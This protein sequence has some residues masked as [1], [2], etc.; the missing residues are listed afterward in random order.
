[1]EPLLSRRPC[2]ECGHC[3][4]TARSVQ[5]L[6]IHIRQHEDGDNGKEPALLTP[7]ES[8]RFD[9]IC[10][11]SEGET[12]IEPIAE[13]VEG[14]STDTSPDCGSEKAKSIKT[15]QVSR[16]TSSLL[17]TPE[18]CKL[19]NISELND[20]K[21]AD[22][23]SSAIESP[24]EMVTV[25]SL[26]RTAEPS[27]PA[28]ASD[29]VRETT[30]KSAATCERT[31][32]GNDPTASITTSICSGPSKTSECHIGCMVSQ[33]SNQSVNRAAEALKQMTT[34]ETDAPPVQCSSLLHPDSA[35]R[36]P[37]VMN[38]LLSGQ[39]CPE[40]SIPTRT[41]VVDP[42]GNLT[43]D[44]QVESMA[45]GHQ[46]TDNDSNSLTLCITN[47]TSFAK[48]G[49]ENQSTSMSEPL[50]MEA[51]LSETDTAST[52]S[53]AL[54]CSS[55]YASSLPQCALDDSVSAL[56]TSEPLLI[57]PDT[58]KAQSEGIATKFGFQTD[59]WKE[60]LE[61]KNV[62]NVRPEK[63]NGEAASDGC[64]LY[65]D[66]TSAVNTELQ[67]KEEPPD[68]GFVTSNT[69]VVGSGLATAEDNSSE[70]YTCSYCDYKCVHALEAR[71]HLLKHTATSRSL[72][73]SRTLLDPPVMRKKLGFKMCC[74]T[75]GCC[76]TTTD[77]LSL[78]VHLYFQHKQTYK[79][80]YY[81]AYCKF[82]SPVLECVRRHMKRGHKERRVGEDED[83]ENE[84]EEVI[85]KASK[86]SD[87]LETKDPDV[88]RMTEEVEQER[89]EEEK[90]RTEDEVCK[91]KVME[92]THS[93]EQSQKGESLFPTR[94]LDR[95]N[96]LRKTS[97]EQH[98]I[99]VKKM[100]GKEEVSEPPQVPVHLVKS[101]LQNTEPIDKQPPEGPA[102]PSRE[103]LSPHG[104]SCLE[105]TGQEQSDGT[106][107]D[108]QSQPDMSR[109]ASPG[110]VYPCPK[111]CLPFYGHNQRL[112]HLVN[113][114]RATEYIAGKLLS[115]PR[116]A[117]EEG[118]DKSRPVVNFK[119][120][121]CAYLNTD[122]KDVMKH[123]NQ[124]HK[125]M[126]DKTK[127][128]NTGKNWTPMLLPG[129]WQ[130]P[131]RE[132]QPK[133]GSSWQEGPAKGSRYETLITDTVIKEEP[134][135]EV[136]SSWND[137]ENPS[138]T[139]MADGKSPAEHALSVQKKQLT[140]GEKL[141]KAKEEST[142]NHIK[143]EESKA[144]V[145]ARG[146]TIKSWSKGCACSGC[147]PT[148]PRHMK[149]KTRKK[150]RNETANL[151]KDS[152]KFSDDK[153]QGMETSDKD[154]EPSTEVA[155][156]PKRKKR[157]RER[158]SQ[159]QSS[160]DNTRTQDDDK[161][162]TFPVKQQLAESQCSSTEQSFNTVILGSKDVDS[163]PVGGED[164]DEFDNLLHGHEGVDID[165]P[166]LYWNSDDDEDKEM[167]LL[168]S[169]LQLLEEGTGGES[170]SPADD[171]MPELVPE[172]HLR[173]VSNGPDGDI[174]NEAD[175]E[176]L[177]VG[178]KPHDDESGKSTAHEVRVDKEA[179]RREHGYSKPPDC[180]ASVIIP[181]GRDQECSEHHYSR[182]AADARPKR[183]RVRVIEDKAT[184]GDVCSPKQFQAYLQLESG[185]FITLSGKPQ[186]KSGEP[187]GGTRANLSDKLQ[188]RGAED[189]AQQDTNLVRLDFYEDEV[190][191]RSSDDNKSLKA[192][193]P[194][195]K[196]VES[197]SWHSASILTRQ[198]RKCNQ[199][200][201]D[202]RVRSPPEEAP[203]C[204]KSTKVSKVASHGGTKM[205][206]RNS[207]ALGGTLRNKGRSKKHMIRAEDDVKLRMQPVVQ[208]YDIVDA[209]LAGQQ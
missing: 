119:C 177:E 141:Q 39:L 181:L 56:Y 208:L 133:P 90:P 29:C 154:R 122:Y 35:E 62:I 127:T 153:V 144:R 150:P 123:M 87:G 54:E 124:L 142:Q 81:C 139:L 169:E 31:A 190:V 187:A 171:T 33:T 207:F 78:G 188:Q 147:R 21:M 1:M 100:T 192:K 172:R 25:S 118:K 37:Q 11:T 166:H 65:T 107:R 27:N 77:S 40:D 4:F 155:E 112:I 168:D 146:R 125:K 101:I 99:S 111:C 110:E 98:V 167:P 184:G 200:P 76:Y 201:C 6:E 191:D 66:A 74:P 134:V 120:Y 88:R 64:C 44:A 174:P 131:G 58:V 48:Q 93:V 49:P 84:E 148:I 73:S 109:L 152:A 137:M 204:R 28:H 157:R 129:Q 36:C 198:K 180:A 91:V 195:S 145:S 24:E 70:T 72:L 104:T 42:S 95:L 117:T 69:S 15:E 199:R 182:A 149:P 161:L 140:D 159:K 178:T 116:S 52:L 176:D 80:L 32:N 16:D 23:V 13:L 135:D 202:E 156:V 102:M 114:H 170:I 185:T 115:S 82:V 163:S 45:D 105:S 8:E 183:L 50:E 10:D 197:V 57:V 92:T 18:S 175:H 173:H 53:A 79:K 89:L 85:V 9:G 14:V 179:L 128:R 51:D 132:Q 106:N 43:T 94:Y 61:G 136:M 3:T 194:D 138:E 160:D 19:K 12:E 96:I 130:H 143:H 17:S 203:V 71:L 97:R 113:D 41:T 63:P 205:V 38:S 67:I 165:C 2:Y 7:S 103:L 158:A 193:L 60:A 206:V 5:S 164:L 126:L 162:R 34:S 196:P 55:N 108:E 121:F 22:Q 83:N 26:N 209:I 189:T 30:E 86:I 47:V 151:E 68:P 75:K 186:P 20:P 59:V 46:S